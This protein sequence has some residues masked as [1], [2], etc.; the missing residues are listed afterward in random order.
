MSGRYARIGGYNGRIRYA[1]LSAAGLSFSPSLL[2]VSG[3]QGMWGDTTIMG[4][5]FQD[6][7]GTVPVTANGQTV[8]RINDKLPS[9]NFLTLSG[10]TFQDGCVE[11]SGQYTQTASFSGTYWSYLYDGNALAEYQY[12]GNNPQLGDNICGAVIIDRRLTDSE[13][14]KL[15]TYYGDQNA[16]VAAFAQESYHING[17]RITFGDTF[18]ITRSSS[19]YVYGTGA[20]TGQLVEVPPNTP[21]Y[22]HDPVTGAPLGLSVEGSA[23][24]VLTYGNDFTQWFQS[25][26]GDGAL[27][28][29][30]SYG[31]FGDFSTSRIQATATTGQ[32]FIFLTGGSGFENVDTNLSVFARSLTG[33]SQSIVLSQN[34][35]T[36]VTVT[37][38]WQRLDVTANLAI[39]NRQ[40]RIGAISS[41]GVTSVDIEIC[42][43]QIESGSEPTSPIIT[44]GSQLTRSAD[45]VTSDAATFG[46]WYPSGTSEG[47]FVVEWE[48]SSND[49]AWVINKGDT[50]SNAFGIF[51][52]VS[53]SRVELW[54]GNDISNRL[55]LPFSSFGG[56]VAVRT[57]TVITSDA[58]GSVLACNGVSV[59]DALPVNWA[60]LTDLLFGSD[61]VGSR[62][63]NG[64]MKIV[65]FEPN[66]ITQQSA[67]KRSTL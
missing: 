50:A 64:T 60:G 58:T 49:L 51:N 9:G 17:D 7:A 4:T 44:T 33:S 38:D 18:D 31:L 27:T 24:N 47:T 13:W 3:E 48:S 55:F 54:K 16:L 28:L 21:A 23:T 29:T 63:L 6:A 56:G 14:S 46:D 34:A 67:E 26:T 5:L 52:S 35:G 20:Q 42:I 59:T 19:K 57:R 2:F 22:Q 15:R 41:S 61:S 43:A 1:T 12:T 10:Y 65:S 11:G 53:N 37:P 25:I 39:A 36:T 40:A 66:A 8:E 62:S 30:P 45:I 32:A